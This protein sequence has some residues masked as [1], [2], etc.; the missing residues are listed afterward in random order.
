MI[1]CPVALLVLGLTVGPALAAAADRTVPGETIAHPLPPELHP[2]STGP[3]VSELQHRLQQAGFFP[4][5]ADGV[6]GRQTVGAVLAFQKL[7]DLE[8]TGSFRQ[9]DWPLLSREITGPG[10]APEPDRIEVDLR[11]QV[12]YL[13]ESESVAG[14]FPISS[15]NGERY[16]NARGRIINAVTPEGRFAFRRSRPGWW[17][18]YLGFLYSPFYFYG[19][20]AVHGSHSVPAFPASHGCVRMIIEDMDFLRTRLKLGMPIY[21]YG[22]QVSREELIPPLGIAD[23][24]LEGNLHHGV[25]RLLT[26]E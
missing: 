12:L 2:G 22:D 24:S 11:R 5:R 13:I 21:L 1:R 17:Q 18:S 20:Y 8:R 9:E 23:Q 10:P 16:R 25:E 15:A 3:T 7:Y 6:Y 19:G 14:V 4:G 26:L